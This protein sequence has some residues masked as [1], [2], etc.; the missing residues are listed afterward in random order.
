MNMTLFLKDRELIKE[1][2]KAA[3][4][5]LE[6]EY[7]LD[8]HCTSLMGIYEELLSTDYAD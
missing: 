2:G 5:K 3:R 4:E 7:S 8:E 6:K 1:I